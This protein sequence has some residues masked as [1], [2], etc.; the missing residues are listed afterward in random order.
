MSSLDD[1]IGGILIG[2]SLFLTSHSVLRMLLMQIDSSQRWEF[3]VMNGAMLLNEIA[4]M[5]YM[6]ASE[7]FISNSS[8][9]LMWLS[10]VN[11]LAYFISKPL[12]LWL[13]YLRCR[14]VFPQWRK[15]DW[16]HFSFLGVRT[17]ELF[18][19][20]VCNLIVNIACNGSYTLNNQCAGFLWVG[21][22]RDV[23]APIWRI[24]YIISESI[25]F[26]AIFRFLIRRTTLLGTNSD[27]NVMNIVRYQRLQATIFGFDLILLIA[28]SIYRMIYVFSSGPSYQYAELFSTALTFFNLTEFG[29]SLRTLYKSTN[30]SNNTRAISQPGNSKA[31]SSTT[32]NAPHRFER[33]R[34][35]SSINSISEDD[36]EPKDVEK[37]QMNKV[38][39]EYNWNQYSYTASPNTISQHSAIEYSPPPPHR[40]TGFTQAIQITS[41]FPSSSITT[42]YLGS[43]K[44]GNNSH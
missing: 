21:K 34:T 16:F 9:W 5:I 39:P 36:Y 28:M 23:S 42:N 40:S 32:A 37:L 24:Y 20:F 15:A 19:I 26:V 18:G 8:V 6:F 1:L 35:I 7:N 31:P 13:S 22:I 25:F 2:A 12:A 3:P 4:V 14:S 43:Q 17:V 10:A 11:N 27:E 44:I 33:N 29:L 38:N 30:D 41:L